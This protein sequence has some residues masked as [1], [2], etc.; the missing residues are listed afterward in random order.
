MIAAL[1]LDLTLLRNS[2]VTV[3]FPTLTVPSVY[4]GIAGPVHNSITVY[5][6]EYCFKQAIVVT[7][8]QQLHSDCSSGSSLIS[9]HIFLKP[10]QNYVNLY[11]GVAFVNKMIV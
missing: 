11:I 2:D 4:V 8:L 7:H 1:V 10:L 3:S 6:C 5:R 9:A